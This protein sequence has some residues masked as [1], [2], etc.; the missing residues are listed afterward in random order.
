MQRCL[1]WNFSL[2]IFRDNQLP[3]HSSPLITYHHCQICNIIPTPFHCLHHHTS[4]SI[5]P[6][7]L[8]SSSI[9]LPWSHYHPLPLISVSSTKGRKLTSLSIQVAFNVSY[10]SYRMYY[11]LIV[12]T[13]CVIRGQK[14]TY[15]KFHICD[16]RNFIDKF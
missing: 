3:S 14:T 13:R 5:T 4:P 1:S 8:P 2:F 6:T 10:Y 16:A 9:P 11:P 15:V 7:I 12:H